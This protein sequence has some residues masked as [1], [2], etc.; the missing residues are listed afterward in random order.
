MIG[1]HLGGVGPSSLGD[2]R[3]TSQTRKLTQSLRPPEA[4][5]V[6]HPKVARN[7]TIIRVKSAQ[8]SRI[9]ESQIVVIRDISKTR[10]KDRRYAHLGDLAR[11]FGWPDIRHFLQ[12][13]AGG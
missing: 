13:R 3:Q 10:T 11:L 6:G 2:G 8:V 7:Q 1:I 5:I 9:L 12:N 4:S